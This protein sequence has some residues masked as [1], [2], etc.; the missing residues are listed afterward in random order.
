MRRAVL[1]LSLVL[2]ACGGA[3]PDRSGEP[4]AADAVQILGTGWNGQT[5]LV[6]DGSATP[7]AENGTDFGAWSAGTIGNP[8]PP[9][10]FSFEV[11]NTGAAPVGLPGLPHV[12]VVGA[13]AA[14]FLVTDLCV[15]RLEG[16]ASMTFQLAFDGL[17]ALGHHHAEVVVHLEGRDYRFAVTGETVPTG[18]H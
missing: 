17:G 4:L 13:G 12:E 11:R 8:V 10:G 14:R 1:A 5:G 15:D 9:K 6:P 18:Q 16:G 7:S 2:A 3:D